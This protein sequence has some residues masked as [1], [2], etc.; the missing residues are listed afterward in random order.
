MPDHIKKF[1]ASYGIEQTQFNSIE[2][3]VEVAD[4]LYVTR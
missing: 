4:V 2:E 1:V 3:V